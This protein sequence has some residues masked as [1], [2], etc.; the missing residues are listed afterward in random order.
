MIA[1]QTTSEAYTR[2]GF[3]TL[4]LIFYALGRGLVP[5][6]V[7]L[8]FDM[9]ALVSILSEL[10]VF[11]LRHP[12]QNVSDRVFSAFAISTVMAVL[13]G[14]CGTEAKTLADFQGWPFALMALAVWLPRLNANGPMP[15]DG[16]VLGAGLLLICVMLFS[17]IVPD[18]LPFVIKTPVHLF[19]WLTFISALSL[20]F[21]AL[22][23]GCWP[24]RSMRFTQVLASIL[25]LLG[26]FGTIF[27]LMNALSALPDIFAVGA[28]DGT[29]L[30]AMLRGLG[31][32]F[33]TTLIGLGGAIILTL[34]DTLVPDGTD[35]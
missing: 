6:S 14:V 22:G 10:G 28:P 13:W 15:V 31:S 23:V 1:P 30:A 34:T 24:V 25:P 19:L 32:A 7:S 17:L 26:F 5:I 2:V 29:A 12:A 33:E 3:C 4:A 20:Q 11:F 27:G 21:V 9:L 8:V 18:F 35:E 16:L